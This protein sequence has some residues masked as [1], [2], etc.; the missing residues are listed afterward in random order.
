ME[1]RFSEGG[2]LINGASSSGEACDIVNDAFPRLSQR[3]R[4]VCDLD[5]RDWGQFCGGVPWRRK[6]F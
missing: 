5:G 3:D 4:L 1:F 2:G 6:F